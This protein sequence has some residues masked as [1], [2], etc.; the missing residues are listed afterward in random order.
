MVSASALMLLCW[1]SGFRSGDPALPDQRKDLSCDVALEAAH[2]LRLASS[3]PCAP[4]DI[5]HG[6]LLAAHSRDDNAVEC[7]VGLAVAAAVQPVPVC[8]AAGGRDRAHG[9]IGWSWS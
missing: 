8:P 3:F 7:G 9:A 5:A 1:S 6:G 4:G 2:D